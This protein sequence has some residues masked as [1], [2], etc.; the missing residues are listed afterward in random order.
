M[1][2]KMILTDKK[3]EELRELLTKSRESLRDIRFAATGSRTKDTS[4]HKNTKKTIARLM[5]ELGARK[6]AAD[7]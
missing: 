7:A 1:A 2:K 4:A 3:D 6:N 5:T